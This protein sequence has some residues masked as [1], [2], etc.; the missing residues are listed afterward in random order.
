MD[1]QEDRQI[2]NLAAN[3]KPSACDQNPLLGLYVLS[4]VEH[5]TV[6]KG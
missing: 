4:G 1:Q 2:S 5:C 6:K 3:V